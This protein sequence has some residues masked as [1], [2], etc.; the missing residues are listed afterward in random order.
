MVDEFPSQFGNLIQ[1]A[2]DENF[3]KFMS[4]PR[5]QELMKNKSFK[6]A[7]QEKNVFKLMSNEEFTEL[8]K[9][10]EIRLTLEDMKKKFKK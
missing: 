7:V 9:D 3:R 1:F 6:E 4:D 10:P 8:L 2:K 5:V